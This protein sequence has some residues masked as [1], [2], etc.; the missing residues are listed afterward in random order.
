MRDPPTAS[1]VSVPT[2]EEHAKVEIVLEILSVGDVLW[3]FL[4]R[5][6]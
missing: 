6:D 1:H 2:R 3:L 5:E 4:V